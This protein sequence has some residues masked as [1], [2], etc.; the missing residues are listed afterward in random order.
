[1]VAPWLLGCPGTRRQH[2]VSAE[3]TAAP[4]AQRL[5]M[6]G[7]MKGLPKVHRSCRGWDGCIAWPEQ[8][9]RVVNSSAIT[10]QDPACLGRARPRQTAFMIADAVR[11]MAVHSWKQ[12]DSD[13]RGGTLPTVQETAREPETSQLT[14]RFRRWWQVMDSN[15]RR[16]SRRFTDLSS[17]IR[18][19]SAACANAG[20][21]RRTE[22]F[23]PPCVRAR[24]PAGQWERYANRQNR[25]G[26]DS[27]SGVPR[28]QERSAGN[29]QERSARKRSGMRDRLVAGRLTTVS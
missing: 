29:E 3:R 20:P 22:S 9:Q 2:A 13:G 25:S 26:A 15:Q 28:Q 5:Y 12:P 7:Y 27:G 19:R 11:Y 16:L 1:M 23:R 17:Y 18:R 10:E 21:D 24:H 6:S 14:G 8:R 4:T